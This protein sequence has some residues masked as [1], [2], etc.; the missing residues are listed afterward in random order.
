VTVIRRIVF[1]EP[2]P[3]E[4]QF[5]GILQKLDESVSYCNRPGDLQHDRVT[6]LPF[7]VPALGLDYV[8]PTTLSFVSAAPASDDDYGIFAA[9]HMVL[10]DAGIH[11]LRPVDY[12]HLEC[13]RLCRGIYAY[14][15]DEPITWDNRQCTAGIEWGIKFDGKRAYVVFEGS[16]SILDWIRD[17]I[18]FAPSVND[19][20]FGAMW[21]GFLIGMEYVWADIKPLVA[22]ADE[23]VFTGHSLGAARADIAA[24]YALSVM[25]AAS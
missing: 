16:K 12:V 10:Y 1:G 23:I 8:H 7:A 9:H 21:G 14:P 15:G 13:S 18:G 11:D 5:S 6:D 17:L 19:A 25:G 22:N 3:G 20:T 4:V 24:A 2:K